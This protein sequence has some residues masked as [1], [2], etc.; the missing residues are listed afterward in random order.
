M[1]ILLAWRYA[2]SAAKGTKEL[3]RTVPVVRM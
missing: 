1:L 3:E 2:G